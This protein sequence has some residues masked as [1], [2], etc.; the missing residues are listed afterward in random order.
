M[1]PALVL[2]S[3]YLIWLVLAAL[4]PGVFTTHSPTK[5]HLT[6]S[7]ANPLS[8]SGFLGTDEV[9]RDVWARLVY[10]CSV[11]VRAA[12]QS[13]AIAV[14]IGVPLGILTGYLRGRVGEWLMRLNDV[15]MSFPALLFALTLVAV[16]GP[17]INNAM[18]AIGIIFIPSYVRLVRG[19][20]L[21][22]R[23]FD[24]VAASRSIGSSPWLVVRRH[25]LRA[26]APALLVQ[27][28]LSAGFAMLAEA[29]LSYLGL[30]VQLPNPSW[31][32]MMSR[33]IKLMDRAPWL[34]IWP[35][36]AL[37]LAVLAL[38]VVGDA[39]RR[40]FMRSDR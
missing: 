9:G 20:V 10:S 40:K 24:Y 8:G 36:V 7:L 2:A 30:G 39:L 13:V 18:I 6:N 12:V 22:V 38:N 33:G 28:A 23:E 5:Q 26:I 34:V 14:I 1:R 27:L 19:I 21:E 35:G 37:T 31:G 25:I 17:G 4:F 29:S 15:L 32:L 11:A 16:L 3:L